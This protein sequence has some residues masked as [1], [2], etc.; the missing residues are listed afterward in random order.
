MGTKLSKCGVCGSTLVLTITCNKKGNRVLVC[1]HLKTR[2]SKLGIGDIEQSEIWCD[3]RISDPS[4]TPVK[5]GNKQ[6]I[7]AIHTSITHE[8]LRDSFNRMVGKH[9]LI[10]LKA[11]TYD[12]IPENDLI[13][14]ANLAMLLEL[15]MLKLPLLFNGAIKLSRTIGYNPVLGL[16]GISKGIGRESRLILDNLGIVFKRSSAYEHFKATSKIDKLTEA[17]KS[18]A[19]KAYAIMKVIEKAKDT[20]TPTDQELKRLRQSAQE[21]NGQRLLGDQLRK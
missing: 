13:K 19:W 3:Q 5:R 1:P 8:G 2:T 6:E 15:P 21:K 12:I 11:S 10:T 17:Q 4:K 16:E 14:Q 7:E 20:G 9:L 18:E